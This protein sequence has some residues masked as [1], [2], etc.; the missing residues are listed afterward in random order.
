MKTN[1]TLQKLRAGEPAIGCFLG[2]GS[3]NLAELMAH[4]GM[5]WLVIETEHNALDSAEIE[6]MI[7]AIDGTRATPIV[8]VPNRDQVYIQRALDMGAMGVLVPGVRSAD[9]AR[10]VV[11]YT[12]YPPNGVRSWGPLRASAYTFDNRD[13]LERADDNI[14]VSL[15][16]ETKDAV[17]N[18][19]E[20]CAVPGVDVLTMGPWD[21]SLELGL[22]PRELP[23][24]EIDRITR[25]ALAI[26]RRQGVETGVSATDPEG[27]RRQLAEGYRFIQYGPDYAL[28]AKAVSE[29]IAALTQPP[30]D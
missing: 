8:R 26:G 2:L 24:P 11:S 9:E 15:I 6:R 28:M 25:D 3:P 18:I 19:D 21:L 27:L 30:A 17:E 13:Y 10:A 7:M 22:D 1:L 29:G 23:H 12:R 4:A 16:L 5:D 14:L 20:I